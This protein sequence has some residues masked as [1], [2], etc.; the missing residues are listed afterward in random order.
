MKHLIR[1]LY[2]EITLSS[3]DIFISQYNMLTSIFDL[4]GSEWFPTGAA[5]E[6]FRCDE[7]LRQLNLHLTKPNELINERYDSSYRREV[8]S[9]RVNNVL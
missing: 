3:R 8:M 5:R 6:L 9:V 2:K 1:C 4:L 7:P